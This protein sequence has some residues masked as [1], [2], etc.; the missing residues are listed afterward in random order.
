MVKIDAEF[1]RLIPALSGDEFSQ[2][3]AN[4]L[5]DGIR[6]PLVVWNDTLIDGHNRYEIATKHGIE[7]ETQSMDFA[8]RDEAIRWIILNQFG[9]RNLSAYDRSILA[10]RLKPIIAEKAKENLVT[11]TSIGYEGCH[12][13]DKAQVDTKKEL[14]KVA[15]VSHNTIARVEKIEQHA[16]PEIKEAVKSGEMSINQAYQ[17]TRREEKKVEVEQAKKKIADEYKKAEMKA[18]IH[19]GDCFSYTPKEKY[20]LLLTDPPYSTDVTDIDKFA[21][22]WLPK[23]LG[24]VRDDGFA[25]VFIGAYPN[26]LKAYLNIDPPSHMELVQVLVWSYRNTLGNN[27]K[28][29]YKQNYQAC[30]FYRGKNAPALDCPLTNE[31]WAVQEINAPDGRQGDRFHAWQKPMEIA[32][33]FIRHS[34][35]AGDMVFDPFACTGTFL[36]AAAKLGRKSFG[37]EIDPE[38]AEIAINRGCVYG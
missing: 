9:R 11:H 4:I 25:Y 6:E 17:A 31:Q 24:N 20:K 28:D 15:G 26:E 10:L 3:E 1:K 34:T 30:L 27:P 21:K 36:L 33:R 35:K 5:H 22:S 7:Y 37:I 14:A 2:L 18:V 19:V 13:C 38:N 12:K 29:R 32:E 8:S 16:T 23:A